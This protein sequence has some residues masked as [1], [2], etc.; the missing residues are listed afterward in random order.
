[1]TT[2]KYKI[3]IINETILDLNSLNE[4]KQV[5]DMLENRDTVPNFLGNIIYTYSEIEKVN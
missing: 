1:M 2:V 3:K 5:A 4:A